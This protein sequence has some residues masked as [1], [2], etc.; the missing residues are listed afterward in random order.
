[1]ALIVNKSARAI[2]IGGTSLTPNVPTEI[3]SSFLDN[4]RVKELME[5]GELEESDGS[6]PQ[7]TQQPSV[8]GT[9]QQ[10]EVNNSP[11]KP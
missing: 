7:P 11:P 6:T 4:E 5:S 2:I 1:M 8:S 9:T 10:P 3:D